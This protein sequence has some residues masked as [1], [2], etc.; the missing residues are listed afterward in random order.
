MNQGRTDE[1]RL[2]LKSCQQ[3]VKDCITIGD[4][5]LL[6]TDYDDTTRVAYVRLATG[7]VKQAL[8]I[9]EQTKALEQEEGN[10]D[11][12]PAVARISATAQEL[13]ACISH[14]IREVSLALKDRVLGDPDQLHAVLG[15]LKDIV[16]DIVLQ[17]QAYFQGPT[18]NS[19]RPIHSP[20]HTQTVEKRPEPQTIKQ[21]V[22]EVRDVTK[23]LLHSVIEYTT[24]GTSQS[25]DRVG[26][27]LSIFKELFNRILAWTEQHKFTREGDDIKAIM[28]EVVFS[29][30]EV[31][32][33]VEPRPSKE[34]VIADLSQLGAI[35]IDGLK[36]VL[37]REQQMS[38]PPPPVVEPPIE[39]SSTA[40][41]DGKD[42]SK[43]S[44]VR[45]R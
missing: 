18:E 17:A 37:V 8:S 7:V 33:N 24:H 13:H 1:F 15:S 14:Y 40:Q 20:D 23:D 28:D 39:S 31:V 34:Q 30:E 16:R 4:A 26:E 3:L 42:L 11:R 25:R 12:A 41:Q 21:I 5:V 36:E 27:L 10:G 43:K 2:L 6:R 19:P 22:V 35:I 45:E 32:Y 29:I 9:I 44:T 38:A